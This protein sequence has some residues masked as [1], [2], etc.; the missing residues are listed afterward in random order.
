MNGPQ[1]TFHAESVRHPT[2]DIDRHGYVSHSCQGRIV[3]LATAHLPQ[4]SSSSRFTAGAFEFFI[5]SQPGE[6]P[7]RYGESFAFETMPSRPSLHACRNTVFPSPFSSSRSLTP[8]RTASARQRGASRFCFPRPLRA[9]DGI[10]V[11]GFPKRL[12]NLW[13][14][15]CR[16][17]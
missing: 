3:G 2:A 4:S 16:S 14:S 9:G 12:E 11:L 15:H 8:P 6:R 17:A 13:P 5:L 7:E 10:D 1:A